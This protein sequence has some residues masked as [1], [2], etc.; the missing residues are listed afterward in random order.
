MSLKKIIIPLL[1]LAMLPLT[2]QARKKAPVPM[3][4]LGETMLF[5]FG[6]KPEKGWLPVTAET[7]YYKELGYGFSMV[8]FVENDTAQLD[9]IYSDA[10]KIKKGMQ[11]RTGFNV[12]L[13]DGLYEIYVCAGNVQYM[14]ICLEG[15]PAFINLQSNSEGRLEIPVTD[16]QLNMTFERGAAGFDLA[17]S[18]MTIQRKGNSS[19]RKKR[20]FICG[21]STAAFQPPMTA[22]QPFDESTSGGWGQM[23]SYYIPDTLYVHNSSVG[24]S[25]T[26]DIVNGTNLED[27][28]HFAMPGD[29]ALISFGINDKK[30]LSSGEYSQNLKEIIERVR[31]LQCVPVIISEPVQLDE[32]SYDGKYRDMSF[33]K[34]AEAAARE[35]DVPFIDL[36]SMYANYL[37]AIGNGE[38]MF[39]MLWT[40]KR[41]SI[42]PNRTGAAHMARLIAEA[43]SDILPE[44]SGNITDYGISDDPRLKCRI[45]SGGMNLEN[46]TERD[47]RYSLVSNAFRNKILSGVSLETVTI[48]A[49]NALEPNRATVIDISQYPKDESLYLYGNGITIKIR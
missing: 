6:E 29:Y 40:G 4:Q 33:S 34:E 35:L 44:F 37:S 11:D 5:D 46:T 22:K 21:D 16:G 1:V 23:L 32:L 8:S 31:A 45:D 7:K 41:D 28:L 30:S 3:S 19:D 14:N 13:P 27:R 42:H 12:D 43:L 17:V 18:A 38:T 49:Y 24:G 9:Y 48:P 39:R 10:V 15:Y 25:S 36:H 2:A 20:V 47:M 26:S